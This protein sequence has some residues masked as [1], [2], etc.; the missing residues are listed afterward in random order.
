VR[1]RRPALVRQKREKSS[2]TD[3]QNREVESH[4][5]GSVQTGLEIGRSK[6]FL[7]RLW[8]RGKI[9]HNS[10]PLG[11]VVSTETIK[12]VDRLHRRKK[13]V[14]SKTKRREEI[15][16]ATTV[17]L[18]LPGRLKNRFRQ[19]WM[20]RGSTHSGKIGPRNLRN[21]FN[22]KGGG[23]MQKRKGPRGKEQCGKKKDNFKF[24]TKFQVCDKG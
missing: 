23:N 6:K 24:T 5:R 18:Q 19:R 8:S 4:L 17:T 1:D 14:R 9:D 12:K 10:T 16:D 7:G 2:L 20:V 15:S 13:V 22:G 3:R 21:E 11:G